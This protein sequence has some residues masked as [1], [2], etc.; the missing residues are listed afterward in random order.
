MLRALRLQQTLADPGSSLFLMSQGHLHF[1]E[2]C[3]PPLA[4]QEVGLIMNTL[5]YSRG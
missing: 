1:L 5:F 2:D 4:N 3:L